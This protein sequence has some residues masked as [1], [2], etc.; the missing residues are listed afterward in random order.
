[1]KIIISENS[2]SKGAFSSFTLDSKSFQNKK[3]GIVELLNAVLNESVV[4]NDNI[5]FKD[6][7]GRLSTKNADLSQELT[8][9][10]A[11]IQNAT[12]NQKTFNIGKAKLLTSLKLKDYDFDQTVNEKS[13]SALSL[14]DV[15][16]FYNE[17]SPEKTFLTVAGDVN[18]A[19]AKVAVKNAFGNWKKSGIHE[20]T[21]EAK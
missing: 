9:M 17:I 18:L 12:I 8:K 15:Q 7:S 16:A 10:A 20:I 1:M 13:I 19:N 4:K 2:H 11:V 6:N 5:V 3:D 21:N 14:L